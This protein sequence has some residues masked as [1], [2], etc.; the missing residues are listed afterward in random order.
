MPD[1]APSVLLIGATGRVGR[2][3]CHHWADAAPGFA[4]LAA[5]RHVPAAAG[6]LIWSPLHGPAAL[7]DHL[8]ASGI[9]PVAMIVLAGVTPRPGQPDTAL[10]DNTM[11]AEACALAAQ[12]CAIPRV[13][14]A[15]SSAVYGINP[16]RAPFTETMLPQPLS[17]YGHAKLEMEGAL[18]RFRDQAALDICALRIG[19]VAG[20]DALLGPLTARASGE[21]R[22]RIDA[23][24]DGKGPLRSYIGAQTFARV[25]AGLATSPALLPPVLNV[26]AP[27]PVRMTALAQAAGWPHDM[28]SAPPHALQSVTLD[29]SQLAGLC[30]MRAQDNDPAAMVAQW[31]ATWT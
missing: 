30:N 28:V 17:A 7:L 14:I 26:A 19:N 3:V 20:A 1:A 8:S 23:F 5:G 4:L 27:T 29:C 21:H 31:K 18:Q 16:D 2:M 24:A 10:A 6:S 9:S 11:L 25:L 15:S 22:L 12:T 13:L